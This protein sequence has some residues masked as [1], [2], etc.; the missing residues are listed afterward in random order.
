MFPLDAGGVEE[1]RSE[2]RQLPMRNNGAA[3]GG[4]GLAQVVRRTPQGSYRRTAQ[5]ARGR[6]E[7]A[8]DGGATIQ[9]LECWNAEKLKSNFTICLPFF[10]GILN[11]GWTQM[12]T[13]AAARGTGRRYPVVG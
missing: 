3:K 7:R 12:H 1:L 5:T 6:A 2:P 10:T 13:D 9:K 8:M 4:E 11:H